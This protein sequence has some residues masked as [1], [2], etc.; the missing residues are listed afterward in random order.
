MSA[1]S[2]PHWIGQYIDAVEEL[3]QSFA[4]KYDGFVLASR[5]AQ[6]ACD[7]NPHVTLQVEG[8][9]RGSVDPHQ[10]QQHAKTSQGKPS[11]DYLLDFYVKQGAANNGDSDGW[12]LVE[13]EMFVQDF[14]LLPKLINLQE[15]K[16][17]WGTVQRG[18]RV[19]LPELTQVLARLALF[20]WSKPGIVALLAQSGYSSVECTAD[21]KCRH[22]IHYLRL[23][24]LDRVKETAKKAAETK[25]AQKLDAVKCRVLAPGE[26]AR[27]PHVVH[28]D[29][30]GR[31]LH[32]CQLAHHNNS[33]SPSSPP[34]PTRQPS[35]PHL[36]PILLQLSSASASAGAAQGRT[37]PVNGG[38]TDGPSSRPAS[39]SLG[40]LPPGLG[41][42]DAPSNATASA[43][44]TANATA[45]VTTAGASATTAGAN[46]AAATASVSIEEKR[47]EGKGKTSPERNLASRTLDLDACMEHYSPELPRL[48]SRYC[49]DKHADEDG[50][51]G[52]ASG[53]GGPSGGD[54]RVV[55]S[56]G[57]FLDLGRLE[58][59]AQI[60]VVV[61]L[62][63]TSS[64]DIRLDITARDFEAHTQVRTLPAPLIP[65]LSRQCSVTF[66]VGS[67]PRS[68][69]GYVDVI[70]R[71][72]RDC[73]VSA[74]LSI[75]VYY[76][77]SNGSAGLDGGTRDPTALHVASLPSRLRTRLG[78]VESPSRVFG[79]RRPGAVGG[80]ESYNGGSLAFTASYSSFASTY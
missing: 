22:L 53:A 19:R 13:L 73:T 63:N 44:I 34:R 24:D 69:V 54:G 79:N 62:C 20:I 78:V 27:Q 11:L 68:V 18:G 29:S 60:A 76:Y 7:G 74:M 48:F 37:S 9:S 4:H 33:S 70:F 36:T 2:R 5:A 25:M 65:G 17:L 72:E 45:T 23:G 32:S 6:F 58:P 59:S 14:D 3:S 28:R 42:A 40:S 47:G 50:L 1:P 15:L 21:A 31:R 77:V 64:D 46:T 61:T 67:Q 10:P 57:A 35:Y 16:A 51:G 30:Q 41:R 56:C 52:G 71:G 39:P 43:S 66:Q 38:A 8:R 80:A 12:T 26:L 75:P 55:R 49:S